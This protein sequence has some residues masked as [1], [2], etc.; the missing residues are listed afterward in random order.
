MI[1]IL[2]VRSS[3]KRL[4]NKA[5]LTINKKKLIEL[6]LE[7][8]LMSK[9][10]SKVIIATSLDNKDKIFLKYKKKNSIFV[11]RGSLKNVYQR[12]L[13]TLKKYKSSYFLRICGDS[14]YL[15]YRLIDNAYKIFNLH[16]PDLVTNTFERTY[17][18]GQSI[19]IIKT[20]TF[21]NNYKYVKSSNFFKEH[22]TQFFYKNSKKFNIFNFKYNKNLSNY[23]LSVDTN[24]DLNMLRK[25]SAGY[26]NNFRWE[27]IL[28]RYVK[29]N[30]L[31]L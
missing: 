22:V 21:V 28:N 10:I 17:P 16:K 14:P 24:S 8:L 7:R 18:K 19:E 30:R 13:D 12:Y 1:C 25:I 26:K 20:K 23:N 27:T 9:S 11:Y 31:N 4:K 2:Q 3:S 5:N 15:D 29:L 6:L